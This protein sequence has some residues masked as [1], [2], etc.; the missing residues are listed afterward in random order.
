MLFLGT[1]GDFSRVAL[2]ALLADRLPVCAVA[3]PAAGNVPAISQPIIKHEPVRVGRGSL[4]LLTPF[5]NRTIAQIAW[6]RD[7]PVLEVGALSSAETLATL[8][9]LSASGDLRGLLSVALAQGAARSAAAGLPESASRRCCLPI[10]GQARSSG[11]C[12][13]ASA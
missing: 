4:P 12:A 5:M 13:M 3:M 11:C 10:A 8:A 2:E 7:I 6:E 1:A 9:A